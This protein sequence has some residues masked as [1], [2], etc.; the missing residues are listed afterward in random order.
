VDPRTLTVTKLLD[1]DPALTL[2]AASIAVELGD[3]LWIGTF[4]GDRLVRRAG[5]H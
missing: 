3:E 5:T 1:D 4:A 2:G